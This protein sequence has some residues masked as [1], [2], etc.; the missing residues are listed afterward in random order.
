MTRRTASARLSSLAAVV[1]LVGLAYVGT[2]LLAQQPAVPL[3]VLTPESL[4][5]PEQPPRRLLQPALQN[6][7]PVTAERL[8][9]AV[10]TANG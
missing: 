7:P 8:K 6:Y 3:Q 9:A 4:S 10:Q 2:H 1:A 5:I